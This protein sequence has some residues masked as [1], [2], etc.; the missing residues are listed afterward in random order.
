MKRFL[1]AAVVVVVFALAVNPARADEKDAT[2]VID[3]AI[4]ALGGEEK[5]AKAR[6]LTWKVKGTLTIDGNDGEIKGREVLEKCTSTRC[7]HP[8]RSGG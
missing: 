4:K 6:V 8:R 2:V 7:V 3:K 5:L 1:G